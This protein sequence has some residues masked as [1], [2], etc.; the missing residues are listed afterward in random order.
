MITIQKQGI[1]LKYL[2]TYT[3]VFLVPISFFWTYVYP[4]TS[5]ILE[6]K[7]IDANQQAVMLGQNAINIQITSLAL[8]PKLIQSNDKLTSLAFKDDDAIMISKEFKKAVGSNIIPDWIF[9]YNRYTGRLYG[10]EHSY[11]QAN[12]NVQS[13]GFYFP[14]WDW[15]DMVDLLSSTTHLNVRTSEDVVYE[16]N[17][18]QT[19]SIVIPVP[20]GSQNP[21]ASILAMISEDKLNSLLQNN[22]L[23]YSNS[24]LLTSDKRMI[25][26]NNENV[27]NLDED[28]LSKIWD[29]DDHSTEVISINGKDYI[30]SKA[31]F[32]A[33]GLCHYIV[34][35]RDKAY[36]EL[37]SMYSSVMRITI[38]TLF[39]GI[40]LII[41]V[42]LL[43]YS[44]IRALRV[45]SEKIPTQI[46]CSEYNDF[47]LIK[48]AIETLKVQNRDLKL[49]WNHSSNILQSYYITQIVNGKLD[50]IKEEQL[51]ACNIQIYDC[52]L[53][54]VIKPNH[55]LDQRRLIDDINR[56]NVDTNSIY[57]VYAIYGI[58]HENIAI[59]FTFDNPQD[60]KKLLERL[61]KLLY[62]TL[63]MD[64]KLGFG[65]IVGKNNIL[66][67]Y[68]Q[69][70]TALDN[71]IL[72]EDKHVQN[73][74]AIGFNNIDYTRILFE[75]LKVLETAILHKNCRQMNDMVLSIL[76][77]LK[78]NIRSVFMLRLCYLCTYHVLLRGV[79]SET[80]D[81]LIIKSTPLL[82]DEYLTYNAVSNNLIQLSKLVEEDLLTIVPE[83]DETE[84][85]NKIDISDVILY[86]DENFN[87]YDL[88]LDI[89]AEKYGMSYSNFSHYFKN[90]TGIN[91]TTYLVQQR[92]Q[93]AQQLLSET[94]ETIN[95]ISSKVG[96]SNSGSF[97]RNFKNIVQ[98]TPGEYRKQA[99]NAK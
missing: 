44:P 62:D 58:R 45:A 61:Q 41:A 70:L 82:P 95:S 49:K 94:D 13:S 71:I 63:G 12:F 60:D 66:S 23:Q 54:A 69:S 74:L 1:L 21:Y 99:I 35:E 25:I 11:W 65:T 16:G 79:S 78:K 43:N 17:V 28:L 14:D 2:I 40:I 81:D 39:V 38:I 37:Y 72:S 67:S 80:K 20:L 15:H 46:Q 76:D 55:C 3:I 68:M 89:I 84:D 6:N 33:F 59:L 52:I 29:I 31:A 30:V 75:Q 34:V 10:T 19:A 4:K 48:I 7:L 77:M 73:Y 18:I 36:L 83:C 42:S 86:I 64:W 5:S 90:K 87:K 98:M 50:S 57:N 26:N 92:L 51:N 53:I 32:N 93:K 24:L 27:L 22:V 91:F 96:F 85:V 88:S 56:I 8:L 97:T 47:D 9:L